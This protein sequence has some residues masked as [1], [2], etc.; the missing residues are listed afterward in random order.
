MN[1]D[2]V[3]GALERRRP[4]EAGVNAAR[5]E[6]FLDAAAA[7]GLELHH[8]MMV[9]RDAV[10]A[11]GAW[12]PYA[13]GSR[14]MQHS[15]T[16]SWTAAAMGVAVGDGLVALDD[17]VIDYFP[18]H[19]PATVSA[20][21]A[22]MTVR[23][24]LTMR[25]GH[26]VGISGGEWRGRNESWVRLFL[27]VP[28]ED[29][30]GGNFMYCSGTS[31]MLSAI[32]S[33][34]S[35]KTAHEL[36]DARV[37]AP[38]GMH[39]VTWDVSPEGYNTGGNGLSCSPE[40]M[41]KFGLLH[42]RGGLWQGQRVLPE[43]WVRDATRNQVDVAWIGSLAGM[44]FSRDGRAEPD[45]SQRRPGYGYQW[46]M[47]EDGGFL[48]SGF[49]G[50]RCYVF[51]ALDLVLVF[52]AALSIDD[53][54]LKPLIWEHLLP[55]VDDIV[56]DGQ[57]DDALCARLT[58]LSLPGLPAGLPTS[59]LAQA[60]NGRLWLAEPNDDGIVSIALAFEHDR[61]TFNYVDARGEHTIVAGIG[62]QIRGTTTMTGNKLHH[63]YQPDTLSVV[64][65]GVWT[66]P[67][68]FDMRWCF[69]ETTFC[70]RVACT[71]ENGAL[72]FERGVNTNSGAR[73][74]PG[75][76]CVAAS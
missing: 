8:F 71:F 30:P 66:T 62:Q 48:A 49:F 75:V 27:E 54:A 67:E 58:A 55:A 10:I 32:V 6:R 60:V 12:R 41:A 25:T 2:T 51:P 18:E 14:H 38:L 11:E 17:R 40:D 45:A 35:G 21:L 4:S 63:E 73:V 56:H 53:K 37:F 19:L 65:Q 22:A 15:A 3:K 57:A 68:R 20:N 47:T 64:A 74:R 39:S 76:Q 24:L 16:K 31:Y 29:A 72:R 9:R 33:K 61:C 43:A 42:L 46:W 13:R 50:Q 26:R 7:A 59:A 36:L 1:Q 23:D 5:V 44:C 52:N 70:D 69:D 28:V 34:A